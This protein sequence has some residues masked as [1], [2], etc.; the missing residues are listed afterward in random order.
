MPLTKAKEQLSRLVVDV[1]ETDEQITITRNGR[2]A[3][4][5]VRRGL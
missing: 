1:V 2:A 3:A 4:V 5:L